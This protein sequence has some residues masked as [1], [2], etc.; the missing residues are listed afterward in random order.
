LEDLAIL[1][2]VA[3]LSIAAIG[4]LFVADIFGAMMG[5]GWG[6]YSKKRKAAKAAKEE[7]KAN[8]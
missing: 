7:L 5:H 6:Y 1:T 8:D 4:A 3:A 2:A